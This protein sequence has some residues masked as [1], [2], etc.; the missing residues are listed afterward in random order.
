VVNNYPILDGTQVLEKP[1]FRQEAQQ[2]W[3]EGCQEGSSHQG[4]RPQEGI[5]SSLANKL[6]Y[7]LENN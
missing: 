1:T 5:N 2:G 6:F 7:K 3:F 4:R